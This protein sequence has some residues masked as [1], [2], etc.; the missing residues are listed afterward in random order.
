MGH[1]VLIILLK[2][3]VCLRAALIQRFKDN[4][5]ARE[6]FEQKEKQRR[7]PEVKAGGTYMWEWGYEL[8]WSVNSCR[9][10]MVV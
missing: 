5:V 1:S 9:V 3:S 10:N 2:A 4:G 7:D 8:S 6:Y